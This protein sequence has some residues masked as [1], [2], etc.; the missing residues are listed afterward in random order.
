[1]FAPRRQ[2]S[3]CEFWLR[4]SR[5]FHVST[6]TARV[7][8]VG[9]CR[10]LAQLSARVRDS[11][12]SLAQAEAAGARAPRTWCAAA[13]RAAGVLP[14]RAG[15]G[16]AGAA[17]AYAAAT[18]R[19]GGGAATTQRPGAR[20]VCFFALLRTHR[21]GTV[22][23]ELGTCFRRRGL[24]LRRRWQVCYADMSSY[25]SSHGSLHF[26]AADCIVQPPAI[27]AS[28]M[29]M[30]LRSTAPAL[31][32]HIVGCVAAYAHMHHGAAGLLGEVVSSI[33]RFQS[34]IA[35]IL[36]GQLTPPAG[37]PAHRGRWAPRTLHALLCAARRRC[38][39]KQRAAGA[40]GRGLRTRV[41]PLRSKPPAR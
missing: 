17:C 3:A 35:V 37:P 21:A 22:L 31:G 24:L 6:K 19:A 4:P 2:R 38:T 23:Q 30:R 20:L 10:G 40:A 26:S 14:V 9:G 15:C 5:R 27:R 34:E 33:R 25:L 11:S 12:S 1:M 29:R 8:M 13:L 36:A 16:R 28:S 18:E 39:S 41:R 7:L 32:A